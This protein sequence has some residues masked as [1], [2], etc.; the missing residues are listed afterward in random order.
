M[1]VALLDWVKANSGKWIDHDHEFG[2]QCVD[3]VEAYL[4]DFLRVPAWPGNAIDFAGQRY[5]GW[6]WV[7][8]KRENA[9]AAGDVV[10]WGGPNV[11]V[12]TSAY[13]HC[14]IALAATPNTML[15]LSQNWPIGATTRLQLTDYR[16]VL[17]WQHK[18]GG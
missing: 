12:G 10:V 13:G 7:P 3:L 11:E 17:G 14:A 15:V 2:A 9:P 16:A 6:T 1:K 4:A 5:A 18:R 8:N